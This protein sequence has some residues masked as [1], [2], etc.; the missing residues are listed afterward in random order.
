MKFILC[1]T[2]ALPLYSLDK[3]YIEVLKKLNIEFKIVSDFK[4]CIINVELPELLLLKDNTKELIITSDTGY[5]PS[6]Y[7]YP[8]IEIYDYWRE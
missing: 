3:R 8:I 2:D 4:L 5:L 7:D 6:H 1:N